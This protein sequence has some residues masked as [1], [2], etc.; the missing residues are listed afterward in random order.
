MITLTHRSQVKRFILD[1][2][3]VL[4]IQASKQLTLLD[5]PMA[6][7]KSY[8]SLHSGHYMLV[9]TPWLLQFKFELK[10]FEQKESE[11]E[12]NEKRL[13]LI[14]LIWLNS[15]FQSVHKQ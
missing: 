2:R 10:D 8:W 11:L 13:I 15:T 12:L 9:T 4:K 7:S 3:R 1:V 14:F 5:L 6:Y